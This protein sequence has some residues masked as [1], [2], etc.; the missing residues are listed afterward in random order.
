[1]GPGGRVKAE[2]NRRVHRFQDGAQNGSVVSP[3]LTAVCPICSICTILNRENRESAHTPGTPLEDGPNGAD[4][5]GP[6]LARGYARNEDGVK[7]VHDVSRSGT[8][9][10][11]PSDFW[12]A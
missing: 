7:I 6:F 3:Y 12:G 2:K 10:V 5:T 4:R 1:M 11:Y 9:G 8:S